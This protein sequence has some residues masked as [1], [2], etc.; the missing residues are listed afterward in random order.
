[1]QRNF[2]SLTSLILKDN[3]SSNPFS[4]YLHCFAHQLQLLL[5]GTV[6]KYRKIS[7]FFTQLNTIKNVVGSCKRQNLFRDK[8]TTEVI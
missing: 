4:F 6:K 5:V 3:P 8:K 2:N 1:M 7:I